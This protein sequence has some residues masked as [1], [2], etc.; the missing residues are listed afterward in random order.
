MISADSRLKF[1]NIATHALN[2]AYVLIDI[3]VTGI[4]HRILHFWTC[5]L[6]GVAYAIFTVIYYAAGA[7]PVY[8]E[9]VDFESKPLS[10]AEFYVIAIITVAVIHCLLFSLYWL[11]VLCC[12]C[13][14]CSNSFD[15]EFNEA[16]D[17]VYDSISLDL[18]G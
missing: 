5:L 15:L 14:G 11:R 8:P 13:C 1:T 10:S 4:P 7:A 12:K 9:N 6:S 3:F 2:S 16:D 17:V 18:T